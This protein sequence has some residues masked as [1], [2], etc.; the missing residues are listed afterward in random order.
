VGYQFSGE[1]R[2]YDLVH[3][4]RRQPARL[5]VLVVDQI[6]REG[7]YFGQRRTH[8]RNTRANEQHDTHDTHNT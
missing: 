8:L 7:L 4:R 6:I 2:W 1:Q 5:F 3:D